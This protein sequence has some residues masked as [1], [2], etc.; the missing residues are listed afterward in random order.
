MDLTIAL[1]SHDSVGLGHARRNRTLAFA[2][3]ESLPRLTGRRVRG[4][5]IAGH[6]DAS[7]DSLPEGWDWM[8]LPGMTRTPEGYGARSLDV[9]HRRIA[10]MRA[11]TVRAVLAELEPDL[12]I[13][14]RHPYGIDGELEGALADQRRR[15]G[16]TV[17]G[18][19]EVL[20]TPDTVI[21]EW[22]TQGGAERIAH[23]LD[24]IWLY[25]DPAVYDARTTGELPAAL[26]SLAVPTGYLGAGRPEMLGAGP[27]DEDH[28]HVGRPFVLTVLGGGSDG[29]AVA[30]RTVLA[31]IPAGHD[32]LVVT[33]PQMPEEQIE[34]LRTLAGERTTVIRSTADVPRLIEE[35]SAV[36]CMS[37]YNT[38]AEVLATSTPA[39]M[40]PRASRREE[41]PRRAGALAA[42]GAVETIPLGELDSADV[43]AWFADAVTRRVDRSAIDIDGLAHVPELAARLVAAAPV[44]E[45]SAAA[46]APMRLMGKD[47]PRAQVS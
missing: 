24:A 21:E 26:A 32:H 15:G 8:I 17:L 44:T 29:F 33:G 38:S 22:N 2:L 13:V 36:V 10:R 41:Q 46:V 20:D 28:S 6:P 47:S 45:R 5:L 23:D 1:F 4:M 31:E 42:V 19:R 43:T 11:R 9:S 27:E 25:G 7:G 30:R 16:L 14:D 40:V 18:L 3:A 12:L 35:S 37:G 34:E 39:L